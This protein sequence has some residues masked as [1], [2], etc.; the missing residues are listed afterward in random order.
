[1]RMEASRAEFKKT[2]ALDDGVMDE[3]TSSMLGLEAASICDMH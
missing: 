3:V 1:M 2:D